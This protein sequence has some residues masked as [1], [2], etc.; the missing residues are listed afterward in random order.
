MDMQLVRIRTGLRQIQKI[1]LLPH[2]VGINRLHDIAARME[3]ERIRSIFGKAGDKD[4]PR[5]WRELFELH[6]KGKPG[7]LRQLDIGKDHVRRKGLRPYGR[8]GSLA[9]GIIYDLG[10]RLR[11]SDGVVEKPERFWLVVYGKYR[12]VVFTCFFGISIVTTVPFPGSD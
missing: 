6:G 11:F 5:L 3:T 7:Q 1:Q 12:H 2:P 4:D 9:V 10:V 8:Q